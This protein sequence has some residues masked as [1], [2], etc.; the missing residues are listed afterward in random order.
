MSTLNMSQLLV[1]SC[2]VLYQSI[3]FY[4]SYTTQYKQQN[5]RKKTEIRCDRQ[6]PK[7]LNATLIRANHARQKHNIAYCIY[8]I[9]KKERA[10]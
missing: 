7:E 1:N 4:L 10:R 5:A 2:H 9:R 3:K 6:Y 8:D